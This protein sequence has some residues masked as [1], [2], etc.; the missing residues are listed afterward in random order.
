MGSDEFPS[1]PILDHDA[2]L[3]RLGGDRDLYSEMAGFMLE[4][5]PPLVEELRD[6][7]SVGNAKQ[8]REKAHALKGL[9]A[10]TGGARCA[11]AAQAL[12][13]AG[14]SGDLSRAKSLLQTLDDELNELNAALRAFL[15]EP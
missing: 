6:A 13:N 7:I 5:V 15:Q 12:E 10:G 1:G 2:A 8:V 4:D 14:E 9:V 3:A 11:K